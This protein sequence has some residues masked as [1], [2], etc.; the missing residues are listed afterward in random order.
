MPPQDYDRG[1]GCGMAEGRS[2]AWRK[3]SKSN[4]S[5]GAC[6][7]FAVF[8]D[9]TMG[10]RDSKDPTGPRLAL[11]PDAWTAF[12]SDTKRGHLDL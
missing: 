8:E 10:V 7:E 5:G 9:G 12:L 3:A 4:G 2:R 1:R 11:T 6:V